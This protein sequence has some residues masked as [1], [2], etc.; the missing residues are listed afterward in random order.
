MCSASKN[1]MKKKDN[2]SETTKD[3]NENTEDIL[4]MMENMME[5]MKVSISEEIEASE[6]R[7]IKK[8]EG[9]L[10]KMEEGLENLVNSVSRVQE[11]LK[12]LAKNEEKTL[13]T[14]E[15]KKT[16]IEVEVKT[17]SEAKKSQSNE[18]STLEGEEQDCEVV[19]VM[20]VRLEEGKCL[21][22]KR[23]GKGVKA[24]EIGVMSGAGINLR[25]GRVELRGTKERVE[26]AKELLDAVCR[27]TVVIHMGR[28]PTMYLKRSGESCRVMDA[29]GARV[30]LTAKVDKGE[31]APVCI[32]GT[33]EEVRA[34]R[35]MLEQSTVIE[36]VLVV[37]EVI[38]VMEADNYSEQKRIQD[39]TGTFIKARIWS[40]TVDIVG[41]REGVAEAR[42][43]LLD[44]AFICS[45]GDKN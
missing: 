10:K 15:L 43:I 5:S 37:P 1:V 2:I 20:T 18:E 26:K 31:S 8:V 3:K 22:K 12:S 42:R 36:T 7:V 25:G 16:S 30:E 38:G 13:M 6:R 28:L 40:N 14:K 23:A 27:E 4:K 34:A 35:D 41:S 44:P 39:T 45:A 11:E 21:T 24:N 17:K 29:T 19:E 33:R 9:S 32:C